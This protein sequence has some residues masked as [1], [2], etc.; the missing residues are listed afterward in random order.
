MDQTPAAPPGSDHA[1]HQSAR[2]AAG[3]A[4]DCGVTLA[5][6]TLAY[7]TYGTLSPAPPTTRSWSATR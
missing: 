6:V 2:F 7:R 5:P 1:A 3:L 4:L